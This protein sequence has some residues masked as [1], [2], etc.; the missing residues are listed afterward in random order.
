VTLAIRVADLSADRERIID[1]LRHYLTPLSD[2]ARFEWLYRANPHGPAAAWLV[3]EENSGET[4][5][6]ASAFPRRLALEGK[7]ARCWVL[8]DFC[9]QEQYRTLG[10]ALQLNRV[11]L[12]AVD[13]GSVAFCYDFPSESMMAV[14][15]R[16]GIQAFGRMT[17][18]VKVLRWKQKLKAAL[19]G[20]AIGAF[21]GL[22]GA[23]ADLWPVRRPAPSRGISV[24]LSEAEFDDAFDDLD[25]ANRDRFPVYLERSSRYLN[26]RYRAN[27]L[28]R[29]EVLAARR[30]REVEGYTVFT[31]TGPDP[32]VVDLVAREESTARLLLDE[33]TGLLRA[34]ACVTLS[35]PASSSHPLVPLLLRSGFRPRESSPVILY[36]PAGPGSTERLRWDDLP[37][38]HGDR[39]S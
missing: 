33:A 15:R 1:T 27:P 7:D 10:P 23:A 9:I 3:V 8:G 31:R 17:R 16:L 34:R 35:I 36:H 21:L 30:G 13:Q 29:Y 4:I 11:C 22:F 12:A 24:T 14:Y 18:F 2:A 39:D 26:W 5:G 20:Q 6:M 32:L 37:L 38:L 25:R 28:V 19:P